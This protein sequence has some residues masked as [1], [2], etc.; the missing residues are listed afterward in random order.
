MAG[1]ECVADLE[2]QRRLEKNPQVMGNMP[3]G[4]VPWKQEVLES[5]RV[6]E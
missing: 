6:V 5:G 2:Q 3:D 4:V 1:A